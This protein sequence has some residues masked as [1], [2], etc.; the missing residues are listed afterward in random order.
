MVV[1][2]VVV[3]VVVGGGQQ[4]PCVLC[5]VSGQ[6]FQRFQVCGCEWWLKPTVAYVSVVCK[7][8]AVQQALGNCNSRIKKKKRQLGTCLNINPWLPQLVPLTPLWLPVQ[9]RKDRA[10]KT[11]HAKSGLALR[12]DSLISKLARPH[13]NPCL[14][15]PQACQA[16][17]AA[18]AGDHES[19]AH[20]PVKRAVQRELETTIAKALLRGEFVE[21][22]TVM[23]DADE[24]GLLLRKGA[25]PAAPPPGELQFQ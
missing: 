3:V 8:Y 2:V 14:C 19:S 15:M 25:A 21:E 18:G 23:V 9:Q 24:A 1:V 17:C 22:D 5:K 4:W 6:G 7:E 20:L 11:A 12:K 10:E 13:Q 16:R